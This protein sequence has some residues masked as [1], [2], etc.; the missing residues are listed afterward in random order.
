MGDAKASCMARLRN[1]LGWVVC[2]AGGAVLGLTAPRWLPGLLWS[3]ALGGCCALPV[4]VVAAIAAYSA[5][6]WHLI[7]RKRW[8]AEMQALRA[9]PAAQSRGDAARREALMSR[10]RACPKCD[11]PPT[12]LAWVY[13]SSPPVTWEHLCGRAGWIT[14]CDHCERQVDFI[15]TVMN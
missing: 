12:E 7:G 6:H 4:A 11:R 8:W 13:Y 10:A 1:N 9:D 2:V 15:L 3:V 5:V 14:L